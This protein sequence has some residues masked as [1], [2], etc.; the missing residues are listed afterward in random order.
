M[1]IRLRRLRHRSL[2]GRIC[3]LII[4]LAKVID[5]IVVAVSLGHFTIDLAESLLFDCKWIDD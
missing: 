1:K 4:Y 5:F 2:K 3:Y